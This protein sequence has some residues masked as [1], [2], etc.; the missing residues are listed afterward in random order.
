MVDEWNPPQKSCSIYKLDACRPLQSE[1]VI[2]QNKTNMVTTRRGGGVLPAWRS[3]IRCLSGS[4]F[5]L[6]G[7]KHSGT[8]QLD[9]FLVLK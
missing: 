9:G 3:S 6:V 5:G 1:K 7:G 4:G 8:V 2:R